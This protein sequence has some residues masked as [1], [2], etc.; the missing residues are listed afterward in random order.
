MLALIR[1]IIFGFVAMTVAYGAISIY[2][3][4]LRRE[5]LEDEWAEDHPGDTNSS[6][7]EA[8]IEQGM[9]EYQNGL[10][11][12]LIWLVYVIPTVLVIGIVV[13]INII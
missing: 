4:S 7:R 12:K 3:R 9:K 11:R 1:L 13:V 2:S 10:R 8:H 6:A 5:K